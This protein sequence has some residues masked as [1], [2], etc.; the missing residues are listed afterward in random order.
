M[1]ITSMVLTTLTTLIVNGVNDGS[2]ANE[3]N[4]ANK[5]NGANDV[6]GVIISDAKCDKRRKGR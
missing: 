6:N 5:V 2:D 1:L 3:V 4:D